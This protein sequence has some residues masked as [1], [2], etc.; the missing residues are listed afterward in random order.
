MIEFIKMTP[1]DKDAEAAAK[2]RFDSIAKPL[3]SLGLLETSVIRLAGIQGTPDVNLSKRCAVIFCADNG[4][5]NEGV[6]Q[7]GSEVTALVAKE[8]ASGKSNI[9]RM[10][11]LANADVFA[12]DIGMNTNVEGCGIINRKISCG[13]NSILRGPAMSKSQA[14]QAILAGVELVRERRD[15]GY[16][17]IVSGEMGIGNTTTSSAVAAVL[18]D[19]RPIE[20]TGRG[21][22][23]TN[24]AYVRKIKVVSAA[25]AV[26]QPDRND[27]LDILSKLGGY[28]IAG[29]TGMFLG[30]GIYHLP[31]VIDGL[32][33]SVAAVLAAKICPDA[34]NFMFASHVSKEPAGQMLLD[35]L[36]L[37][38]MLHCEMCLGEGTGGVLL[39]SLI[40][41]AL[42]VYREAHTF[43]E[44]SMKP[45]ED[46]TK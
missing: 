22:G 28:D 30:A 43:E 15:K 10:A 4:V 38:P 11:Q 26:N 7:T 13:T 31:V 9:S 35:L 12:V 33:S 17:I 6:T 16:N 40:D 29:M 34:V 27:P 18:L 5:V 42:S 8:I 46:L 3:N 20:V 32:I 14:E 2:A 45:Y 19:R 23:L 39:L 41:S 25:I 24:D 21:S 37:K 36:G 44:I 1:P